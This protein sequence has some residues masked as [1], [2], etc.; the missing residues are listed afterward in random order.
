MKL[1][2]IGSGGMSIIKSQ[3][4]ELLRNC[5]SIKNNKRIVELGVD[6]EE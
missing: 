2:I 3:R 5:M 1:K 4:R 6:L